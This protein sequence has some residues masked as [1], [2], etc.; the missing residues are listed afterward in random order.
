MGQVPGFDLGIDASGIVTKIGP[1]VDRLK[2]G[3]RVAFM[4][5][6]CMRTIVRINSKLAQKL[7]ENISY[8][9]GAAIPLSFVMAYRSMVE[10]AHLSKGESVLIQTTVDGKT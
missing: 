6:G 1:A 10:V 3:D 5:P 9:V 8:E 2:V 4:L 7:P